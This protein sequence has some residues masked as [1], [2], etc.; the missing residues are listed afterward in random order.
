[1][2]VSLEP[3]EDR[4]GGVTIE[5]DADWQTVITPRVDAAGEGASAAP[6][7]RC[8]ACAHC[9]DKCSG[10]WGCSTQCPPP[11]TNSE[12]VGCVS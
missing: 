12:R 9:A 3:Q 10:A 5:P 11:P 2:D 1:M 8:D 7:R 6:R 4:K